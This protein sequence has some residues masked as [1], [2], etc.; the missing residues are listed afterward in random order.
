MTLGTILVGGVG[1]WLDLHT[2]IHPVP[3][4]IVMLLGVAGVYLAVFRPGRPRR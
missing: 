2:P 4:A 1:V 3:L